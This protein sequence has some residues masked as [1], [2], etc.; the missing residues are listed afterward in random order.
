MMTDSKIPKGQGASC[1]GD[2]N[3]SGDC[4][5]YVINI[6]QPGPCNEVM[7]IIIL[8]SI[9]RCLSLLML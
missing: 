2:N 3:Q 8:T 4:A 5:L 1:M 6:F 9:F 7:I